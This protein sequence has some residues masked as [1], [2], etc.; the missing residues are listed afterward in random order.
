MGEPIRG[1]CVFCGGEIVFQESD[2]GRVVECPHCKRSME[3]EAESAGS[4][5]ASSISAIGKERPGFP[6]WKVVLAVCV[7]LIGVVALGIVFFAE[8]KAEA[9]RISAEIAQMKAEQERL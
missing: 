1:N 2:V 7:V 6:Y 4:A 9:Q 5:P 3:V 8:K